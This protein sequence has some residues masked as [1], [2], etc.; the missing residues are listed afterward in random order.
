ML[1][2]KAGKERPGPRIHES[3]GH[4]W[5]AHW[6]E[7]NGLQEIRQAYPG[8]KKRKR[9]DAKRDRGGGRNQ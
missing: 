3:N 7:E 1:G 8:F 5:L 4:T 6:E 9:N 2:E